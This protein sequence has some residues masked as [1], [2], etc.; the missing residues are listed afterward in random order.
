M[1]FFSYLRI[2]PWIKIFRKSITSSQE[3]FLARFYA[4]TQL[5]IRQVKFSVSLASN[6]LGNECLFIWIL[7]IESG[8]SHEKAL[9][10]CQQLNDEINNHKDL[11]DYPFTTVANRSNEYLRQVDEKRK[12]L[13]QAIDD[14]AD[15]LIE[16]IYDYK[17]DRFEFVESIEFRY[18]SEEA[19]D[20]LMRSKCD[21]DKWIATLDR[22]K[23]D[24]YEIQAIETKCQSRLQEFKKKSEE[25]KQMF[26]STKSSEILIQ[27]ISDFNGFNLPFSKI[28]EE[29][30]LFFKTFFFR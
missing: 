11:Y 30:F 12:Q 8:N 13:K 5:T 18:K 29:R 14:Y 27:K 24:S 6:E 15:H 3:W 22:L 21:H 10:L 2:P 26:F 17:Q 19:Q 23:V 7:E 9:H 16:R 25:T 1:C 20:K 4:S 28:Q